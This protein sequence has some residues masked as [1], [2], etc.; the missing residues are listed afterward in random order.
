[1]YVLCYEVEIPNFDE[2]FQSYAVGKLREEI[3]LK[4]LHEFTS[5]PL[6]LFPINNGKIYLRNKF[7]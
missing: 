2:H 5:P 4:E 6:H 1:M 7:L 3:I